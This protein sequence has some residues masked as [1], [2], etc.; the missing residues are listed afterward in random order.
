MKV[1]KKIENRMSKFNLD[2][3]GCSTLSMPTHV[4]K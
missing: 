2:L 3:L 4:E 1:L